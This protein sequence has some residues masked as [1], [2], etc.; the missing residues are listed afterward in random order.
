MS[1]RDNIVALA[2][3]WA[4]PGEWK[5]T[6]DDLVDFFQGAGA[7][8]WPSIAEAQEALKYRVTGVKVNGDVKHWC[9]VFACYI[10][11]NAGLSTARW[12]LYG[13]KIKNLALI[14]GNDGM[15][16]GDVAMIQSGNHHF[17]VTDIDYSTNTMHTVEGNTS[18][19]FIRARTRLTTEPYAYYR[20]PE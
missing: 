16:P 8:A 1:F 4:D 7:E 10:V 11:R 18:G 9:G 2:L 3:W 5:P 13:G 17:I 15:Q 19:Q 12:T 20:I 6:E 14:W